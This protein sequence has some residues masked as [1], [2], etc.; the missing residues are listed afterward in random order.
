MA[1]RKKRHGKS[2]GVTIEQIEEVVENVL[3]KAMGGKDE[4]ESLTEKIKSALEAAKSQKD[5]DG[6][7]DFTSD[8]LAEI[9]EGVMEEFKTS[10]GREEPTDEDEK[11]DDNDDEEKSDDDDDEEKS[12]DDDDGEKRRKFSQADHQRKGGKPPVQRKYSN[13]YLNV[14]QPESRPEKKNIPPEVRLGRAVKCLSVFGRNDPEEAAYHAKK[15][16]GDE[17]MAREFKALT[18]TSPSGGG[19]LIPEVYMDEIIELLYTKTVLTELGARKVPMPNGNLTIPKMTTGTRATWG[20]ENRKIAK[21]SPEVGNIKL[22]SKRLEAIVQQSRELVMSTNYTADQIFGE[23]LTRRMYLGLDYGGMFGKGGE[24]Q[25]RG[26]VNTP[27]IEVI[28]AMNM[29]DDALSDDNGK[30]TA[31]FPVHVRSLVL[32]KNVDD[33]ALGWAFNSMVEG[34]LMNLKTTTGAYIYREEMTNG[35]LLGFPFRISNQIATDNNNRTDIL[36]GNWADL[37]IGEQMGLE[38]YTTMDGT[39]RNESGEVVSAFEE[40]QVAT[41]ALMYVD[42]AVRHAESF[43]H[44]KNVKIV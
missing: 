40:N 41:R 14:N 6:D 8:E 22:S 15:K 20:G 7:V 27:G 44:I 35:K 25:P 2:A 42:I 24:F 10:D 26:I 4:D 3:A 19:F 17:Q 33:L 32:A 34:Y 12:D 43:A 28:N 16:Y 29:R 13:I 31:D 36:F 30:I 5:E 21:T 1:N 23:D 37:L 38:T 39:W 18:A 9:L 11:S